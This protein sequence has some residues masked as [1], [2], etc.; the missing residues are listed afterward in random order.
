MNKWEGD[1]HEQSSEKVRSQRA[2]NRAVNQT[3]LL[4][5][6]RAVSMAKKTNFYRLIFKK[7]SVKWTLNRENLRFI[8][9]HRVSHDKIV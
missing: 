2:V 6:F 5:F 1:E 9:K 3:C 8:L 4:S 7:N